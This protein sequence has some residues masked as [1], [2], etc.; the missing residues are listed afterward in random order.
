MVLNSCS[1]DKSKYSLK[2]LAHEYAGNYAQEDIANI[3]KSSSDINRW[4]RYNLTDSCATFWV[5]NKY[6]KQM[7][8]E[9]QEDIYRGLFLPTQKVLIETQLVGLRLAPQKV[10]ELDD[11]LNTTKDSLFG[12]IQ[13]TRVVKQFNED[14]KQKITEEYNKKVKNPKDFEYISQLSGY[15]DK[16]KFNP[17]SHQQVAE[18]LYKYLN[19]PVI[20]TTDTGNPSIKK[21]TLEKLINYCDTDEKKELLQALVDYSGIAIILNTFMPNFTDAPLVD[22]K[23][24]LYGSFNLG[25]TLSGRLSSSE[26]N[27]QNLPSTGTRW[28]K[29]IKELF[30][31]PE[32]FVFVGSDFSSLRIILGE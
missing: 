17:E 4:L 13:T 8:E 24:V 12:K 16:E 18:L 1:G 28:A 14:R 23:K 19:L 22:N 25:G 21:E 6:Y 20:D 27:L 10:Q 5:F 31:A 32:G 15:K 30:Q 2:K 9:N 26:P 11:L 3:G 7:V 29:P